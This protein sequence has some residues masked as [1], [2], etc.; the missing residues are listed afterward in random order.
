MPSWS[1][2]ERARE[3]KVVLTQKGIYSSNVQRK[4][5]KRIFQAE[6]WPISELS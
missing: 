1:E 2:R 4:V 6:T 5:C 3:I